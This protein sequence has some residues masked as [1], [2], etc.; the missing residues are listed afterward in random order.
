MVIIGNF[1]PDL[2]AKVLRFGDIDIYALN[3]LLR[4]SQVTENT[5]DHEKGKDL[6]SK[7][8]KPISRSPKIWQIFL[9]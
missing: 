8:T 6:I 3:N 4:M 9:G 1:A 7:I 5:L 2:P